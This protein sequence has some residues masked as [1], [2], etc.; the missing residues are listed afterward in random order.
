MNIYE[1]ADII[2]AQ[3]QCNR[4]PNQDRWDADFYGCEVRVRTAG[5]L[6]ESGQGMTAVEAV[7]DYLER[8]RGKRLIFHATSPTMRRE[9]VCPKDLEAVAIR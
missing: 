6:S 3:I 8:I 1:F 5:L 4:Y 2:D 7:N 9:Y